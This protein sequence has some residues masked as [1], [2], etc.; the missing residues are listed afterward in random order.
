MKILYFA[1]IRSKIGNSEETID[2]PDG[3]STV[4]DLLEWLREQGPG[5]AEALQDLSVVRV[6]VNEEYAGFDAPVSAGDE[7]A[8][9]PPVTGG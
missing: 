6:A 7:I 3:V 8:L 2:L 1:W 9:F 4:N 5:H